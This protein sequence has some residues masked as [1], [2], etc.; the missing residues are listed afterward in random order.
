[1]K[2]D[3]SASSAIFPK[4]PFYFTMIIIGEFCLICNCQLTLLSQLFKHVTGLMLAAIATKISVGAA[5][6]LL[7]LFV[8]L[9][10]L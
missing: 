6:L 9:F 3:T 7:S 4:K 8:C 2:L 10:V 1:M 5:L